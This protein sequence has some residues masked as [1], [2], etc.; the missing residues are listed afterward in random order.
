MRPDYL[1]YKVDLD[2]KSFWTGTRETEALVL[3]GKSISERLAGLVQEMT[4]SRLPSGVVRKLKY[5]IGVVQKS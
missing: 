2:V 1:R 4:Y 3:Q 5:R